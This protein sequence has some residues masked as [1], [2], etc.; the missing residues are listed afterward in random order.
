MPEVDACLGEAKSSQ[1][2]SASLADTPMDPRDL[3]AGGMS[4]DADPK[5]ELLPTS[6]PFT[7]QAML[8][9]FVPFRSRCC[10]Q[11]RTLERPGGRIAGA[12]VYGMASLP[13]SRTVPLVLD[14]L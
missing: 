14:A 1:L 10:K 2:G 4:R 8:F 7:A 11:Q 13:V 3:G 6:S 12:H 5:F 9:R